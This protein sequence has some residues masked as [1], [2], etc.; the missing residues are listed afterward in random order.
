MTRKAI[1]Y[2]FRLTLDSERRLS[3]ARLAKAI[4]RV[5]NHATEVDIAEAELL[6][7]RVSYIT[8]E[9]VGGGR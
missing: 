7:N 2:E 3:P 4:A 8:V 5:L 6:D 9:A 1:T